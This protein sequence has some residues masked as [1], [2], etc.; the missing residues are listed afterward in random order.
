VL[1]V[2]DVV[3]P[4]SGIAVDLEVDAAISFPPR[5]CT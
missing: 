4:A 1:E 5:S 2:G 3:S